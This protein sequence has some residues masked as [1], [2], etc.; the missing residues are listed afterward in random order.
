MF[1]VVVSAI[2]KK[3]GE[4]LIDG[5]EIQIDI[6]DRQKAELQVV[7][8]ILSLLQNREMLITVHDSYEVQA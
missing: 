5:E 8:A 3:N 4:I 6:Q 1:I 2:D 7:G